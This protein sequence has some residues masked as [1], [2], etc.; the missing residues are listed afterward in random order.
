MPPYRAQQGGLFGSGITP[1]ASA[2]P[3][4]G[5]II[6]GVVGGA[7]ALIRQHYAQ[8]VAD[9]QR[10]TETARFEAEQTQ[11]REQAAALAQKTAFD[12][13]LATKKFGL[14]ASRAQSD[15]DHRAAEL[16]A[17]GI[18]PRQAAEQTVHVPMADMGVPDA[19][20][21]GVD[22]EHYED[23]GGGYVQDR[24]HNPDQVRADTDARREAAADRR[25]AAQI[26]A[27]DRR[28][29]ASVAG[30]ERI[31][32]IRTSAAADLKATPSGA[33]ARVPIGIANAMLAN[34]N[35]T[36]AIDDAIK[37]LDTNPGSV[38]LSN[39][40]PGSFIK[41]HLSPKPNEIATR[42]AI[43]DLASLKIHDRTGAAMSPSEWERL[44]AFIPTANDNRVTARTKLQQMRRRVQVETEA[45]DS[46]YPST[47]SVPGRNG[48]SGAPAGGGLQSPEDLWEDLVN[49]GMATDAATTEVKKLL[50]LP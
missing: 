10:A 22:P 47:A 12:Q 44:K 24:V 32:R 21:T 40:G 42:A 1:R 36:S 39:M 5:A 19:P 28:S 29:A 38:G 7:S 26:A 11:R 41:D 14:E 13:D 16:G 49:R 27:A 23:V 35:A 25:S 17:K 31:A 50:G 3:D 9:R 20:I 18:K 37:L 33:G 2:A 15:A 46:M 8:K 48:A 4:Y 45:M 30:Q 34:R 6:D 43:A